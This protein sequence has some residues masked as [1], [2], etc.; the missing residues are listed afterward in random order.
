[1]GIQV[2]NYSGDSSYLKGKEREKERRLVEGG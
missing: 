1:M 2:V